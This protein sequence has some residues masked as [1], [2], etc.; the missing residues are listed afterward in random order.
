MWCPHISYHI[1]KRKY[2]YGKKISN[3]ELIEKA[4]EMYSHFKKVPTKK[5]ID[6]FCEFSSVL[7]IR[8]FGGTRKIFEILKLVEPKL[9]REDRIN[10]SISEL[11][12]MADKLNKSPSTV[13][14]D[15]LK[16]YGYARRDLEKNL[17]LTWNEILRKYS[18]YALNND[19][20]SVFT[21]EEIIE[22]LNDYKEKVGHIPY[23]SNIRKKNVGISNDIIYRTLEIDSSVELYEIMGWEM[24]GTT[25]LSMSNEDMKKGFIN[26]FKE[27]NRVPYTREIDKCSYTPSSVCYN[28]RFGNIKKLCDELD[29][30][31][32]SNYDGC[33]KGISR[34]DKNGELCRSIPE[35]D[36]TNFLINNDITY[37]KEVPYNEII[38]DSKYRFDWK[39]S[40]NKK[41][42]YIEYFGLYGKENSK[43]KIVQNY[44][45]KTKKKIKSLK[46]NDCLER[47]IFLFPEHY[48]NEIYCD[49]ILNLKGE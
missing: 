34:L 40:I 49:I 15:E 24:I 31:Y 5:E 26:L 47:C 20:G 42:Y 14:Y 48:Y 39:I 22:K 3:E 13:E 16:I 25:T 35:L 8:R 29:I 38:Q 41:E 23:V 44:M 17:N 32:E 27:K 10:I 12:S 18:P 33:G 6:E 19:Q 37:E 1:E 11:I 9:S 45:H 7:Y 43:S 30:D 2:N 21:K 4:K 46:D 36:I 28:S